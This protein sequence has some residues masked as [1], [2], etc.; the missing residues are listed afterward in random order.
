MIISN[1]GVKLFLLSYNRKLHSSIRRHSHFHGHKSGEEFSL[2]Y[3]KLIKKYLNM[4][5]N[6]VLTKLTI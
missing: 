4:H 2:Y 5:M 1:S 3:L 6:H